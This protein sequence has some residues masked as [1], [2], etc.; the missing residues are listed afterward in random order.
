MVNIFF[1]RR[2]SAYQS[3]SPDIMKS[4]LIWVPHCITFMSNN[5]K[6]V[7]LYEF[8]VIL[9][10][11][12]PNCFP[13]INYNLIRCYCNNV[14]LIMI[15]HLSLSRR[16]PIIHAKL[17]MFTWGC[18]YRYRIYDCKFLCNLSCNTRSYIF[19]YNKIYSFACYMTN[20]NKKTNFFLLLPFFI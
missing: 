3:S 14:T 18:I 4:M 7:P 10:T 16:Q 13:L 1:E 2:N 11:Q 9:I 6:L 20:Y 8:I 17:L 15:I 5:I 12:R 19:Y